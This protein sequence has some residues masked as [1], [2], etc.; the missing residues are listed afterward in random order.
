MLNNQRGN[1][2]TWERSSSCG[3]GWEPGWST[4][5][6]KKQINPTATLYGQ[7][8][9]HLPYFLLTGLQEEIIV[10]IFD[11]IWHLYML[12]QMEKA[13]GMRPLKSEPK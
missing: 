8:C 6:T 11:A 3:G 13:K 10:E 7:S 1:S 9:Y 2:E 12:V 4:W 5:K